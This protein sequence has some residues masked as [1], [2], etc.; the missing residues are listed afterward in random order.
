MLFFQLFWC[1][2]EKQGQHWHLIYFLMLGLHPLPSRE[3]T[4]HKSALLLL[5]LL[6]S[7]VLQWRLLSL[8]KLTAQA[9]QKQQ[10]LVRFEKVRP[11]LVLHFAQPFP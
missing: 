7:F 8:A 11:L 10:H 3:V 9:L 4:I 2:P 1:H 5:L 6:S